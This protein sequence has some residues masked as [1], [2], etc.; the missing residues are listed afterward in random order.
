MFQGKI[1]AALDLLTNNRKGGVLHIHH[2]LESGSDAGMSVKDVRKAKHP[3][4]QSA[5]L[6][7]IPSGT[8]TNSPSGF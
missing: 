6:T 4:S 3:I 5:S 8:P 7:D 2:M 1:C